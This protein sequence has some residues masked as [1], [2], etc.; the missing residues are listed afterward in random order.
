V[1]EGK[2]GQDTYYYPIRVNQ[3]NRGIRR[4]C[5]YILDITITRAGATDPDGSLESIGL[6]INMEVEEW[7]E[8][9]KYTVGY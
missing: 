4:G 1:I 8:K 3:E 9:E 7:K 6:E 2:I 5:R